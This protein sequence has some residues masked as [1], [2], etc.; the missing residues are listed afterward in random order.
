MRIARDVQGL[1]IKNLRRK[2]PQPGGLKS[3]S[4]DVEKEEI[5]N[6]RDFCD[7]RRTNAI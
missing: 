6:F 7:T 2:G 5:A 1:D 3:A 4:C